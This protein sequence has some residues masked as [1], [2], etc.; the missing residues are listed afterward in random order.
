MTASAVLLLPLT[1]HSIVYL[2]KYRGGEI[3]R[4]IHLCLQ[5]HVQQQQLVQQQ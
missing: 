2:R 3:L 4:Q 5:L 1:V